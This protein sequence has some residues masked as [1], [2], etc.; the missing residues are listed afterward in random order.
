MRRAVL[1]ALLLL[2]TARPAAADELDGALSRARRTGRV[3]VI[4]FGASWC[5]PCRF[6]EET[7]LSTPAVRADLR[8]RIFLS[9]NVGEQEGEELAKRFEVKVLPTFLSLDPSGEVLERSLGIADLGSPDAFIAFFERAEVERAFRRHEG[10]PRLALAAAADA[11]EVRLVPGSRRAGWA[12][13]R[14][15]VG[16]RLSAAELSELFR[17]H[18]KH[19]DDNGQLAFATYAALAAGD[20]GDAVVVADRIVAQRHAGAV[21]LAAAG[22]AYAAANRLARTYEL[23]IR[24]GEVAT[25][26]AERWACHALGLRVFFQRPAH[27]IHLVRH[28]ARLRLLAA[29]G[30]RVR[31]ADLAERAA[32]QAVLAIRAER[33]DARAAWRP[34]GSLWRRSGLVDMLLGVRSDAGLSGEGRFSVEG[35][36]LFASKL[37]F[38][39]KPMGLATAAVGMDFADELT[40][41]TAAE[42]G[43]A[44]AGGIIGIYSG[45]SASDLGA[46]DAGVIG[47]PI[48]LAIFFPAR[49]TSLHGFVRTQILLAGD[50]ER[51][52]GS[53]D[54]PLDADELSLGLD[55]RIPDSPIMVGIRHDQV[56]DRT[57]TGVW[58]GVQ[59]AP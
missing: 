44:P 57:L 38:D 40:Y 59:L 19:I 58:L 18:L 47:I 6:F 22:H 50:D 45:I 1:A 35:R 30:T 53:N 39:V 21:A 32:E 2:A 16:G 27:A 15:A 26:T 49:T 43:F 46:G 9:V 10:D 14:A 48:E 37:G 29:L 5:G 3:V 31:D 33:P 8:R 4:E 25:T 24:C 20:A 41:E 42:I 36:A 54:A 28:A 13:A 51:L 23:M 7:I 12:L 11:S 55:A 56:L 52:D 17:L 34:P